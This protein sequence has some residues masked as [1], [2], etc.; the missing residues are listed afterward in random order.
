MPA[1]TPLTVH[2]GAP[3]EAGPTALVPEDAGPM[4][5]PHGLYPGPRG[6]THACQADERTSIIAL[7][8]LLIR[9]TDRGSCPG[10]RHRPRLLSVERQ[11]RGLQLAA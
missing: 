7:R 3:G 6:R 2:N 4:R 9:G 5:R 10:A 8:P 1:L 11:A